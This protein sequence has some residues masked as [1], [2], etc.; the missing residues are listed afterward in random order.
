MTGVSHSPSHYQRVLTILEKSDFE[1]RCLPLASLNCDKPQAATAAKDAAYIRCESLQ[2]LIEDGK[3]VLLVMH[4]YGG[5]PGS[6]AANGLSAVER[7]QQGL[8]GGVIGQVFVTALVVEEGETLLS[9]MGG[10]WPEVLKP[11]VPRVFL[12]LFIRL[13]F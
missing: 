7:R 12:S 6:A 1:T 3:E 13:P 9:S 11:N 5:I 10:E 4:S 8:N 2:P